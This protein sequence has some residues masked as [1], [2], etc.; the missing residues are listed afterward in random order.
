VLD[1]GARYGYFSLLAADL[2]GPEGH[3]DAVETNAGHFDYLRQN[4]ALNGCSAS[5]DLHR[6]FRPRRRSSM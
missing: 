4:V 6:N 2:A 5:I 3:V 1:I